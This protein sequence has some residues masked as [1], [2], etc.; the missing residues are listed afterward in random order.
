[1]VALSSPAVPMFA[2]MMPLV[3]FVPPYYAEHMGLGLAVVGTIFTLGRL[4]DVVTDPCAGVVMDKT[5]RLL[6]KHAW[7]TIGAIPLAFAAWQIFFADAPGNPTV[8]MVWLIVLY[9]GWT[10]MSVGIFS[11]ASEVSSDYHERSRVM[12]AVQMANSVGTILVLL[13]PA[14]LELFAETRDVGTLRIHAMGGAILIM[15]PLSLLV[16]WVFA[17]KTMHSTSVTEPVLPVL[18]HAVRNPSLRRLIAADL[19]IGLNIGVFTALSVFFT[20]IVLSLDGRAGTLQLALLFSS[21][22]GLPLFVRLAGR[23]EKHT[24]LSVAAGV[25]AL[26][27]IAAC[28]LP[29]E[30]FVLALLCYVLFGI[31]GGAGQMLPRAIMSDVLDEDSL[32][33]GA[34]STG[35]YFSFLTTTFKL[36]LGLGVG[37][38]YG[39]AELGGFDPVS[40]RAD[41][42]A[43][44]VIR[45]MLGGFPVMLAAITAALMWR[46]PLGRSRYEHVRRELGDGA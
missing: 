34:Q 42:S 45:A 11:W 44:W 6:P 22:V 21:L 29:G 25:T 23:L 14:A 36:G 31:A 46:F 5:R 3:I 37:I 43:H 32:H 38:T 26:G 19:A 18:K 27:G 9:I 16:A 24:T 13:I 1:M 7:V 17:P 4:F 20:E 10:L 28:F 40:A 33:T 39:F 2:L 12:G 41:D 15:L 35:L 30:S 8:L